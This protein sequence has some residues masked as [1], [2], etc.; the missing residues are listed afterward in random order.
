ML[1]AVLDAILG[2]ALVAGVALGK[3]WEGELLCLTSRV[4]YLPPQYRSLDLFQ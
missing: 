2:V 1:D 4:E 3:S